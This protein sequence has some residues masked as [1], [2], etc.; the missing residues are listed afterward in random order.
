MFLCNFRTRLPFDAVSHPAAPP[1][2]P[3]IVTVLLAKVTVLLDMALC[4]LEELAVSVFLVD[5]RNVLL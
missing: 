1:V 5:I 4:W 3:E 2:C